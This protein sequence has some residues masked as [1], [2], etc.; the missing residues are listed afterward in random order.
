MWQ[1]NKLLLFNPVLWEELK[2]CLE[3]RIKGGISLTQLWDYMRLKGRPCYFPN[4]HPIW[5]HLDMTLGQTWVQ[6]KP[7][8]GLIV[9]LYLITGRL[10]T[11]T[12]V[13]SPVVGLDATP[14]HI[15]TYW[16]LLLLPEDTLGSHLSI[17]VSEKTWCTRLNAVPATKR[18][19]ERL[20][21]A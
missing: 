18:S 2:Q 11:M 7:T 12:M 17:P 3:Q 15:P 6:K 19:S 8:M 21:D 13:L 4:S 16:P 10:L 20:E 9:V 14:V 5:D 1:L